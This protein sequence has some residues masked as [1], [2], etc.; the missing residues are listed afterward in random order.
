MRKLRIQSGTAERADKGLAH[1]ERL[2][3]PYPVNAVKKP[4]YI[5]GIQLRAV[6]EA[7]PL[8]HCFD[9]R[10]R[11]LPIVQCLLE[12]PLLCFRG[13]DGSFGLIRE[14]AV[15]CCIMPGQFSIDIIVGDHTRTCTA[16]GNKPAQVVVDL[17]AWKH[18]SPVKQA[19]R[20]AVEFRAHTVVRICR[21]ELELFIRP[22]RS[23]LGQMPQLI[24]YLSDS[25]ITPVR[26]HVKARSSTDLS[27]RITEGCRFPLCYQGLQR[28]INE[29][30][31]RELSAAGH[32]PQAQPRDRTR[33]RVSE[34]VQM[35]QSKPE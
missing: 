27:K 4:R 25:R 31:C 11:Q 17:K 34:T 32:V 24:G 6:I 23:S 21:E 19:L 20:T 12:C 26:R 7:E 3:F 30:L 9:L 16:D 1:M 14:L 29:G 10:I 2:V 18:N 33:K 5:S 8:G 15:F 22:C 13:R 28:S 35:P